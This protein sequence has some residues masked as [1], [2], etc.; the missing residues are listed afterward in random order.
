MIRAAFRHFFY[1]L[2]IICLVSAIL[3]GLSPRALST[4]MT[5]IAGTKVTLEKIQLGYKEFFLQ[6]FSIDNPKGYLQKQG[7]SVGSIDFKA[8]LFSYLLPNIVIE[9]VT[10]SDIDLDIEYSNQDGSAG[11]WLDILNSVDRYLKPHKH[12]KHHFKGRVVKVDALI[13]KN[14]NIRVKKYKQPLQTY[15]IDQIAINNIATQRGEPVSQIMHTLLREIVVAV[16]VKL[17]MPNMLTSIIIIPAE[18]IQVIFEPF[19]LLFGAGGEE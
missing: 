18:L 2:A 6:G 1:T 11:N 13:L 12:H 10:L 19:A 5:T 14:L 15:K 9:E 7:I 4:I 16:S 3:I 17:G 8:H